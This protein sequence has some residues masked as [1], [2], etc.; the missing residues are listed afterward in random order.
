VDV[1]EFGF[2]QVPFSLAEETSA[3][4][5]AT[6]QLFEDEKTGKPVSETLSAF[7]NTICTHKSN[8]TELMKKH[9]QLK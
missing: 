8:V 5:P 1:S 6:D 4:I 9:Q 2:G 3:E 7:L